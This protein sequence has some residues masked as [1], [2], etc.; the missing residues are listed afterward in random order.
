MFAQCNVH[1]EI[2]MEYDTFIRHM[3]DMASLSVHYVRA[4]IYSHSGMCVL[5]YIYGIRRI[6]M[7]DMAC[8][9]RTANV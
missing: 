4:Q 7:C 1:I 6:G 3:C 2:Y 9:T 8:R 5:K